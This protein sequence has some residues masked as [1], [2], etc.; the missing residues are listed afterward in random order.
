MTTQR[1]DRELKRNAEMWFVG[2]F[3]FLSSS[4]SPSL[5]L[6]KVHKENVS[7]DFRS[8]SVHLD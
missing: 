8:I 2:F 7:E 1:K 6:V 5:L 4:P 3:A